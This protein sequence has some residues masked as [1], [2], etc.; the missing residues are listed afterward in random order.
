MGQKSFKNQVVNQ[1]LTITL[2]IKIVI[3]YKT[4]YLILNKKFKM[5]KLTFSTNFG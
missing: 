2:L 5:M 4:K 3:N 1:E